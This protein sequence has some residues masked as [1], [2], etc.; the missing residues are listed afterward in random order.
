[1]PVVHYLV[2]P[3]CGTRNLP[4]RTFCLGCGRDLS[5]LPTPPDPE[6]LAGAAVTDPATIAGG[7][8][9]APPVVDWYRQYCLLMLAVNCAIIPLLFMAMAPRPPEWISYLP[10]GSSTEAIRAEYDPLRRTFF[11]IALL[12]AAVG[13]TAFGI[14]LRMRPSPEAWTY[15]VVMLCLGMGGC[16]L[17]IAV[18]LL[19]HWCQPETKAFF[20]CG[21]DASPS[22]LPRAP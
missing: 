10:S 5:D 8:S 4:P 14:A 7:V 12:W 22:S 20:G 11:G 3:E 17:P 18:F 2:C 16:I 9:P 15:H 1:M 19:I 13:G 21:V 6:G